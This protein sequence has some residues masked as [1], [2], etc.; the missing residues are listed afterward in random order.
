MPRFCKTNTKRFK[1]KNKGFFAKFRFSLK[2]LVVIVAL[3]I[4]TSGFIYILE[5]NSAA[6]KGYKIKDLEKKIEDIKKE[7]KEMQLSIIELQSIQRIN[8]RVADLSLVAVERVE[9]AGTGSA[10]AIAK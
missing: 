2:S 9:Y 6:T 4:L 3:L 1:K 8:Q 10:M 5:V 7:N